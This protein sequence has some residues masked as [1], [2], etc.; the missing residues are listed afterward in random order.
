MNIVFGLIFLILSIVWFYSAYNDKSKPKL[1][2]IAE[3]CIAC[4]Y[5]ILAL[6]Y[7]FVIK[8]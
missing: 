5:F 1:M 6:F 2:F 7:I 3:F 8:F 4:A